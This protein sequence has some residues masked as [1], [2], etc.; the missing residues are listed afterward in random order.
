MFMAALQNIAIGI[1]VV[2]VAMACMVFGDWLARGKGQPDYYY[3]QNSSTPDRNEI[4]SAQEGAAPHQE[5]T[6]KAANEWNHELCNQRR[7]ARAAEDATHVAWLQLWFGIAGLVG[8]GLTVY[9][10]A[11]SARA[12][13][14]AAT[15]TSRAVDVQIRIEQPLLMVEGIA[16]KISPP[17]LKRIEFSVRNL[18]KTAAV[19]I[20]WSADC[21]GASEIA[22]TPQYLTRTQVRANIIDPGSLQHLVADVRSDS[23]AQAILDGETT[24]FFWGY[25]ATRMFSDGRT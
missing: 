2:L 17:E 7:S 18:G 1:A 12:A 15:Q 3:C 24:V 10:A 19:L 11:Q 5:K 6:R 22:S 8:L 23:E 13:G 9:F 4:A 14:E 21:C 20:E 16:S 25:S